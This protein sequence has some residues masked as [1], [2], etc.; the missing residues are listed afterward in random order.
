MSRHY[1]FDHA[2][3]A[4]GWRR[5]VRVT[6]TDGVITA[7]S[8]DAPRDGAERVAGFAVPGLP[9]LHSHAFQRGMAGLA[10]RRGPAGDSFWTWRDVMYRFLGRL[11][12]DDVEA[13]AALAYVEMLERGFTTV[14]EFHYLHH[15]A[16]G[17]PHA[18]LGEMAFRI[19]AAA[20]ET[21]IGLTLLPVLYGYAGFGGQT[22]TQGQRRFINDPE[23]LLRLLE[24][25]R[26]A[27]APLPAD[28]VGI[29][30][31][32]LRAVTARSIS[33]LPSK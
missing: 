3:L 1:M 6:V 13:I 20:G 19:A 4:D 9:N 5:D 2:W 27:C 16:D 10:E 17:A 33:T 12:P 32:S 25:A 11:T 14:G 18:E 30:P 28:A 26:A 23:R 31:H 24:R 22:P 8:A 7:L 15:G 21:G 29:A